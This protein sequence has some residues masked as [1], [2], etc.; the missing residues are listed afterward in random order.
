MVKNF[1]LLFS[2]LF[3]DIKF[4]LVH[5][6]CEWFITYPLSSFCLITG[7]VLHLNIREGHEKF[8]RAEERCTYY[9]HIL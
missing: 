8:G 5:T 2:D 9:V 3:Y 6:L 4:L 7:F 1:F